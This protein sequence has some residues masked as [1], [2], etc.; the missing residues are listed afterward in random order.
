MENPHRYTLKVPGM[1]C[2]GCIRTVEAALKRVPG[3][4]R[5]RVDYLRKEATVEGEALLETWLDELQAVGYPAQV[6]PEEAR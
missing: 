3:T 5:V 1:H 2:S 4:T 6:I